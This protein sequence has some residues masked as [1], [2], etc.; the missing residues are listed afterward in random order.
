[1]TELLVRRP[2]PETISFTDQVNRNFDKAAALTSHHPDLLALIR[3]C[4]SV[5]HFTFPLQRADGSIEVIHAWRAEHSHHKL[6]TK[7]GI[8]Y[9]LAVNEDEIVALAAL[10]TY[11]CAVVDVPFGGAKGG[12]AIDSKQYSVQEL[13]RI[14]LRYAFELVK[15][16]F[17]GPGIDVPAPD[18]GTGPR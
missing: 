4:T 12:I 15:K 1:M 5:Y 6:P 7:G 18:F 9:S 3:T 17:I 11:K 13:E 10:M 2:A 16:N 8:R 14:T